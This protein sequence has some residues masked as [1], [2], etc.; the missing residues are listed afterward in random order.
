MNQ[1]AN[2]VAAK[3]PDGADAPSPPKQKVDP[4]DPQPAA[5]DMEAVANW[6]RR[7]FPTPKDVALAPLVSD[8]QNK[9][10]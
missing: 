2:G 4:R 10:K 1:I 7:H 5:W 9:E 8:P 3:D 6:N